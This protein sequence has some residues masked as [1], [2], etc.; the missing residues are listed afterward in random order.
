MSFPFLER[1]HN[2]CMCLFCKTANC[3]LYDI[4][5]IEIGIE[6]R[7]QGQITSIAQPFLLQNRELHVAFVYPV[8]MP[9]C[10][11]ELHSTLVFCQY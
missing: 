3:S 5:C 7:G 10:C 8:L 4:S 9:L 2:A 1:L 11:R 6:A